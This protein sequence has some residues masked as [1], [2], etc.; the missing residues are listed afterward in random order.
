V[1]LGTDRRR[2][3]RIKIRNIL[4]KMAPKQSEVAVG[5]AAEAILEAV[6]RDPLGTLA[7]CPVPGCSCWLCVLRLHAEV[8]YHQAYMRVDREA[9]QE[10]D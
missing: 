9:E 10:V 2:A 1:G 6:G 5:M 7:D 4:W 3:L 8:L